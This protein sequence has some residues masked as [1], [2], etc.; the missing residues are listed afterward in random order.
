MAELIVVGMGPGSPQGMTREVWE[1]LEKAQLIV[2]YRSYAK[3]LRPLFPAKEFYDSGMRAEAE[4]VRYA[5]AA[6]RQGR[7]TVL[8]SS[9][10]A[11]VYGMAGLCLECLEE[12][13]PAEREQVQLHIL[14]G[15]TAALSAGALLGAPLSNDFCVLS[16]SDLLTPREVIEKRLLAALR[17]DYVL[18]LYNPASQ[19][20][21]ELLRWT[22]EQI[23]AVRG[24]DC[25]C[26]L[27][28]AIG[29]EGQSAQ[30]LTLGE[31]AR[32]PVDMQTTLVIGNRDT[33]V[34]L[35]RLLTPRGYSHEN[36]K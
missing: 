7:R 31:L 3:L 2:A 9:G 24:A 18:V 1:A 13:A 16:L 27:C 23:T 36:G 8:V 6:A 34:C 12:L 15:V 32:T 26:G 4:R 33:R 11:A 29:R 20:R 28:R 22:L 19:Q 25:L 5:I 10:D 21:R 14:P 30:I 17:G 35:G